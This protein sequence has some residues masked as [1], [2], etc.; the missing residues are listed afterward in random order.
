VFFSFKIILNHQ[1]RGVAR[2]EGV[3]SSARRELASEDARMRD[4]GATEPQANIYVC[5]KN[6]VKDREK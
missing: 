5:V 6:E 1:E 4:E 3:P 2:L